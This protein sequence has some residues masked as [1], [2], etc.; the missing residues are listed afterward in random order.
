[1]VVG[2]DDTGLGQESSRLGN[3]R[4]APQC[5]KQAVGDLYGLHLKSVVVVKI[6]HL[7]MR[8]ETRHLIGNGTLKAYHHAER[9]NHNGHTDDYTRH[10]YP[11]SGSGRAVLLLLLVVE[12]TGYKCFCAHNERVMCD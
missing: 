4:Y 11:Y 10:R 12:T 6:D 8:P 9:Q 1:M 5:T 3:V 2:L 7:Y